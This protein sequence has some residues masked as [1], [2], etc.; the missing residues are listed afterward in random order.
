MVDSGSLS[1]AMS[2]LEP[3]VFV[4][5]LQRDGLSLGSANPFPWTLA[6]KE[7]DCHYTSA[8][9]L[10]LPHIRLGGYCNGR[11]FRGVPRHLGLISIAERDLS[12]SS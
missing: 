7:G 11:S 9:D 5:V 3:G 2:L 1:A 4:V 10:E 12:F 8:P 6:N